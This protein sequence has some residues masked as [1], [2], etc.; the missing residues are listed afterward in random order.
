MEDQYTS[1]SINESTILNYLIDLQNFYTTKEDASDI[2]FNTEIFKNQL[3]KTKDKGYNI[4]LMD[5]HHLKQLQTNLEHY[6]NE[7]NGT[8]NFLSKMYII[9]KTPIAAI[10][11]IQKFENN[12]NDFTKAKILNHEMYEDLTITKSVQIL[13]S[14]LHKSLRY[15]N[16][17]YQYQ[18]YLRNLHSGDV[19]TIHI[20]ENYWSDNIDFTF[21]ICDSKEEE[22]LEKKICKAIIVS[23]VY[24]K[25]YLYLNPEGNQTLC[26]QADASR[27]ILIRQNSFNVESIADLKE[28][29]NHL[30][31]FFKFDS[32]VNTSIPIMLMSESREESSTVFENEK[33]I[34]KD[35]VEP[36]KKDTFRRLI[37]KENSSEIQTEIKLNLSSKTNI[38]KN[39]EDYSPVFTTDKFKQKN[40]VNTLDEEYVSSFYIK[41]IL[42]GMFFVKSDNFPE[43]NFEILILGAGCGT[44]NHFFRKI[45]SNKVTIDLVEIDKEYKE[46]GTKYFGFK[47][48]EKNFN[49]FFQNAL[50][51]VKNSEAE[52]KY[53]MIII[54]INNFNLSEGISPSPQFYE[55]AFLNKL[56]VKNFFTTIN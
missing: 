36:E 38:K 24:S 22:L 47:N 50:D 52:N 9:E 35:T 26:K 20:R 55:E 28:K 3:G 39:P 8:T 53:D 5:Y 1:D 51:F 42:S 32:A 13:Y 18:A 56:N 15:M 29:L 41:S 43:K 48:D 12:K 49:W 33:I 34:I 40:L 27:I 46:I 4:F 54:D 25:D 19:L 6:H 16:E 30:I 44:I 11:L 10:V 23:K 21:T 17:M 31:L 14:D 2:Q 7:K 45:F 37:F